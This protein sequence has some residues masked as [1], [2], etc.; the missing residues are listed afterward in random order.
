MTNQSGNGT[1][2]SEYQ[3]SYDKAGNQLTKSEAKGTTTYAY[4]YLN[5]L[6]SVTE[7]D[8]KKT[9]YNYDRAGNRSSELIEKGLLSGITIYS[10]NASNR[11]IS[12][13]S[14]DGSQTAVS[15]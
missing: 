14:S 2:I 13:V 7:P 9:T 3:Y 12:T 5:R 8:G 4:D 10:Y 1:I 11:L 15:V 6:A